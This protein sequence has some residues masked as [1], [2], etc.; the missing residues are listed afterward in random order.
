MR[1]LRMRPLLYGLL[2][3]AIAA[4]LGGG[5]TGVGNPAETGARVTGALMQKDGQPAASA[6][7]R[8]RAKDYLPAPDSPLAGPAAGARDTV[9]DTHGF[10]IF[11]SVTAGE[12][13]VESNDG[14]M[15]G[16]RMA[17]SVRPGARSVMLEDG[18]L[19][20][21]GAFTGV[22]TY[23]GGPGPLKI[24]ISAY[25]L[26]RST[27]ATASGRFVLNDIP[28]GEYTLHIS[29]ASGEFAPL[30]APGIVLPPG[31]TFD[32]DTLKLSGKP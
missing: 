28:A 11:D 24:R 1:A 17:L 2:P 31:A 21:N 6:R 10:F 27:L 12:Y 23:P 22:V 7:I 19:D 3:L 16:L 25:G 8:L 20:S 26:E 9:T 13:W 18:V 15:R 29:A 32:L 30:V 5:G 4:C 14:R